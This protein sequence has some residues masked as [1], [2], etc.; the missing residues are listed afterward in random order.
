MSWIEDKIIDNS[1]SASTHPNKF[2]QWL[3][4]GF[5]KYDFWILTFL[6]LLIAVLTFFSVVGGN[7]YDLERGNT[8]VQFVNMLITLPLTILV[9]PLYYLLASGNT[10]DPEGAALGVG[11]LVTLLSPVFALVFWFVIFYF[12]ARLSTFLIKSK[13][14]ILKHLVSIF[15]VIAIVFPY[16]YFKLGANEV[17]A[18]LSGSLNTEEMSGSAPGLME[19][20]LYT[21]GPDFCFNNI[22]DKFTYSPSS[23][24]AISFCLGL[25][26]DKIVWGTSDSYR[27]YCMYEL[28]SNLNP[29]NNPFADDFEKTYMPNLSTESRVDISKLRANYTSKLCDIYGMSTN[30]DGVKTKCIIHFLDAYLSQQGNKDIIMT[31]CANISN[32][33][34]FRQCTMIPDQLT[35]N[36]K[37]NGSHNPTDIK[38]NSEIII[39]WE[40]IGA[41]TGCTADGTWTPRADGKGKWGIGEYHLLPMKGSITLIADNP[42]LVFEVQCAPDPYSI[43]HSVKDSVTVHVS[44]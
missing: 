10:R 15:I 18:C 38:L 28:G 12:L 44:D 7:F 25:S 17:D 34:Q 33:L 1:P 3:K 39:S 27:D 35:V 13:H 31:Y 30:S 26:A 5:T 6:S 43:F 29:V 8:Y 9:V 40:A 32:Q 4:K 11:I 19:A 41:A 20:H 21:V 22:L 23:K 37:V 36:V 42:L 24:E 2:W 14:S 16:A